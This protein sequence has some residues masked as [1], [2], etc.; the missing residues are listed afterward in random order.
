MMVV[1]VAALLAACSVGPVFEG[2]RPRMLESTDSLVALFETGKTWDEFLAAATARRTT[3]EE[4]Y[5]RGAVSDSALITRARAVGGWRILAVA[6]DWCG[7]SANTIPYLARL[8]EQAPAL[9][10]RIVNSTVGKWVM[11]RY[12]TA[13]GRAATPT[14]IVLDRDGAVQGCLIERPMALKNWITENKPKLSEEDFRNQR[15]EWY[16]ND[17]GVSTVGEF[18]TVLEAAVRGAPVCQP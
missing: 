11:N 10:L 5:G 8:V 15:I 3:W 17:V 14:V 2:P 6:E 7:D 4:N 9:E 16:R 1:T 18:V 13:D 12:Q